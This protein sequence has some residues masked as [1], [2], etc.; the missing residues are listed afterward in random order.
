MVT[1]LCLELFLATF[2]IVTNGD[3]KRYKGLR[4]QGDYSLLSISC[5]TGTNNPT[6]RKSLCQSRNWRQLKLRVQVHGR[7]T[8]VK[9]KREGN[10]K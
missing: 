10:R 5:T 9:E 3:S 1:E 8:S 2:L 4:N 6:P 7:I